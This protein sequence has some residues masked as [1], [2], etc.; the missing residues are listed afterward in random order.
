MSSWQEVGDRVFRRR[1]ASLDLNIGLIVGDEHVLVVDS[2]AHHD[3]ADELVA[4]VREITARPVTVLVNTHH[5]WDHTFGNAR[6][7]DAEVVGHAR[8]RTA[9]IDEGEVWKRHLADAD[10]LPAEARAAIAAVELR[11]P[12]RVFDDELTLDLGGRTVT[13][14]HPGRGHTDDDILVAVDEVLFT[15]DLVEESAPPA[16][17]DSFP[18]AW[19]ETLDRVVEAA[20]G[21]VVPGHG[22]VVDRS[23]VEHQ[24]DQITRAVAGEEVFP[25]DVMALIRHR[26]EAT[27]T[28]D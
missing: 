19:V 1:Y 4:H 10:W 22:D 11:P 8:C 17:G 28:A 21:P 16:F 23:F 2:R 12:T 6:F 9:M 13:L 3:Q 27:T 26:L 7:V 18:R 14:S 24:R 20:A 25:D 15:G 5:H